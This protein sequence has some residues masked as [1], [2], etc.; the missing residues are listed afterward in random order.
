MSFSNISAL[1]VNNLHIFVQ[2][3]TI[4]ISESQNQNYHAIRKQN[5]TIKGG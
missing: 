2:I 1:F 5:Q 4:Q 3:M